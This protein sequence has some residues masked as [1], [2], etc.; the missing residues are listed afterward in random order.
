[1]DRFCRLLS[2]PF[3]QSGLFRSIAQRTGAAVPRHSAERLRLSAD[4]PSFFEAAPQSV[5]AISR[6]Y[7][8]CSAKSEFD[9]RDGPGFAPC[10]SNNITNLSSYVI[11]R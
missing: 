10:H 11:D 3:C 6:L 7:Y 9:K 1:M 8:S 5:D 4:L 2:F